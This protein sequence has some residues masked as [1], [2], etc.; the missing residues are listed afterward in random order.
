MHVTVSSYLV[1]KHQG[2]DE[3]L[4][5]LLPNLKINRYNPCIELQGLAVQLK[6]T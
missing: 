1:C 2:E 3:K 6:L 4:V 5:I